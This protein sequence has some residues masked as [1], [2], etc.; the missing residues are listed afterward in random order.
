VIEDSEIRATV[1]RVLHSVAPDV[2][3]DRL[4]PARDLRRQT[5]LDSFDFMRFIAGLH[6]EL[7]VDVPEDAYGEL[8]TVDRTVVY[9]GKALRSSQPPTV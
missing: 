2:D 5:D 8:D 4:D 9:L 1:L 6:V 3:L 7:G